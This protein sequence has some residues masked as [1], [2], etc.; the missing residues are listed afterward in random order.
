MKELE[1]QCRFCGQGVGQDPAKAH[2]FDPCAV[3]LIANW[4][5]G[6]KEQKEQQ[7]F[8]HFECFRK[9]T[10]PHAPLYLEDLDS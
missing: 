4:S 8:F 5:K 1:Y 9:F 6:E 2:V 7:L 10:S 3:I